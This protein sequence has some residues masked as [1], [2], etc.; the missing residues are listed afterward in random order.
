MNR[1]PSDT[2]TGMSTSDDPSIYNDDDFF[3]QQDQAG[4]GDYSDLM[5][6]T[7]IAPVSSPST[8]VWAKAAKTRRPLSAISNPTSLDIFPWS[9]RIRI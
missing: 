5:D 4:L 8:P 1:Q 6:K 2:D 3:L 9:M 7:I